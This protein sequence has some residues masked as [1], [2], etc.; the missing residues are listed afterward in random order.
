[1]FRVLVPFSPQ[2]GNTGSLTGTTQTEDSDP[3]SGKTRLPE[4]EPASATERALRGGRKSAPR[5]EPGPGRRGW[6]GPRLLRCS[7]SHLGR[8]GSGGNLAHR[9]RNRR[10]PS[11]VAQPCEDAHEGPDRQ[12]KDRDEDDAH[13]LSRFRGSEDLGARNRR[14]EHRPVS[15]ERI[16]VG[17]ADHKQDS[18]VSNADKHGPRLPK[19]GPA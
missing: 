10:P 15:L 9:S 18:L 1:M 3:E 12:A 2:S 16:R 19:M 14:V 6:R 4:L 17:A 5:A 13:R 8:D 7:A 11:P